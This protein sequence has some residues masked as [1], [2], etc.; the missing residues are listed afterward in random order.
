MENNYKI[1]NINGNWFVNNKECE[2]S[3]IVPNTFEFEKVGWCGDRHCSCDVYY[4]DGI[5]YIFGGCISG[6][7]NVKVIL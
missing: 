3:D 1:E 6:S 2:S 7:I 5:T 4:K